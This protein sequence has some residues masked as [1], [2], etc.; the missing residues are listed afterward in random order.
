MATEHLI[1]LTPVL[2]R[3]AY[4]YLKKGVG[5][6][7]IEHPVYDEVIVRELYEWHSPDDRQLPPRG[8]LIVEFLSLGQRIRWVEF[9]VQFIGG[10]GEDIL[11]A[12]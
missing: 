11:R 9:G 8:A 1:G 10:G 5:S 7:A 3:L 6:H 12:I 4:S 2:K